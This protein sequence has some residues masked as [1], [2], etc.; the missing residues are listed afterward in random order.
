MTD[1]IVTDL[2]ENF[3]Q[4]NT[5]IDSISEKKKNN[6]LPSKEAE[7]L[8]R[9]EFELMMSGSK[10]I[11]KIEKRLVQLEKEPENTFYVNRIRKEIGK[12]FV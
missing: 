8:H 11:K 3:R 12:R 4:V 1:A 9:R 5:T 6:N 2:I 7:E 10:L